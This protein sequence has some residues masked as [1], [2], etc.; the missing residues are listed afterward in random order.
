MHTKTHV[1]KDTCVLTH[2]DT[3]RHACTERAVCTETYMPTKMHACV[4]KRMDTLCFQT[5]MTS[6]L[7]NIWIEHADSDTKTRTCWGS[8]HVCFSRQKAADVPDKDAHRGTTHALFLPRTH[9][10]AH[11]HTHRSVFM[12]MY[13]M[14]SCVTHQGVQGVCG[15]QHLW[16]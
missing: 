12:L 10:R 16:T 15:A 14:F 6:L 9:E 11:V 13:A 3:C 8:S 2:R 4:H 7:S 5:K 1:Y